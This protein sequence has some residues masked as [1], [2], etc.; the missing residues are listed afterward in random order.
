MGFSEL[1]KRAANANR[2][3][4]EKITEYVNQY[5]NKKANGQDYFNEQNAINRGLI[6]FMR[7]T[8]DGTP[9]EQA[10]EFN[11]RKQLVE[12]TIAQLNN[13]TTKEFNNQGKLYEQ[14]YNKLL[15]DSNTI[16]AVESKADPTNLEG[17]ET[18]TETW[19][20]LRPD[21]EETGLNV[22]NISLGEDINYTP[23]NFTVIE[24]TKQEELDFNKPFFDP[25]ESEYV[26]SKETGRLIP[27]TRPTTLKGKDKKRIVN[28]NFDLLYNRTL[29]DA[30][31]DINVA[32]SIQQINGFRS[33]KFFNDIFPD[34]RTREIANDAINDYVAAKRGKT[35]IKGEDIKAYNTLNKLATLG[36][37]RALA[38][39]TQP[40][41]Q[42]SPFM[43]TIANA[44]VPNTLAGIRLL[45]DPNV[46]ESMN[47]LGA[48]INLRGI[49]SSATIQENQKS[50]KQAFRI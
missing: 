12:E 19:R 42:L 16:E 30:Y 1:T 32:P 49:E 2:L 21:L 8:V 15:S 34:Q 45:A 22:Y 43:T 38:G 31:M 50:N 40:I 47:K 37:S 48:G 36:V 14:A 13:S 39:I 35:N 5:K 10:A 9:Q 25:S 7:R 18:V 17:V 11:R 23:D 33:S 3:T 24:Q 28:L 4:Q 27:S 29:K 6:A 26:Y 41:K 20:E 44:G 46:K